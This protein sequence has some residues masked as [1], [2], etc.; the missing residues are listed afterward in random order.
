V[1]AFFAI[2]HQPHPPLSLPRAA[3]D[4][5]NM[6]RS[7]NKTHRISKKFPVPAHFFQ[8]QQ[9]PTAR[10][11]RWSTASS[12]TPTLAENDSAAWTRPPPDPPLTK[13]GNLVGRI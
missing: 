12:G 2:L 6:S 13:G 7:G 8:I 4:N 3:A 5:P 1:L 10:R 9:V 11:E